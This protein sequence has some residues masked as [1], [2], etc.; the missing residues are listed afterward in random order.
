MS[1]KAEKLYDR[2]GLWETR[3]KQAA[4]KGDYDRAGILKTKSLQLVAE[5]RRI[6]E[7][8]TVVAPSSVHSDERTVHYP[9]IESKADGIIHAMLNEEIYEC[10]RKNLILSLKE[11][12]LRNID[13]ID[14]PGCKFIII[15]KLNRINISNKIELSS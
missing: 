1:K 11:V 2:A 8:Q 10:G 14:C 13:K 4:L 3:S 12:K 5:A 6:E 15:K 7:K 9:T